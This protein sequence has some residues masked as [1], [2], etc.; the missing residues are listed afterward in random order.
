MNKICSFPIDKLAI[1][2]ICICITVSCQRK[3]L[4][5]ELND[6]IVELPGTSPLEYSDRLIDELH[7]PETARLIGVGEATHGTRE[8]AELRLRLLKYLVIHKGFRCLVKEFSF[9]GSLALNQYILNGT[10]NLDTLLVNFGWIH[11]SNEAREVFIWMREYNTGKSEEDRIFFYGIDTQLDMWNMVNHIT[12]I[13]NHDP[14]VYEACLEHFDALRPYMELDYSEMPYNEYSHVF[15]E[16]HKLQASIRSYYVQSRQNKESA[17]IIQL[18]EALLQ[19]HKFLYH[20][21]R[22][23]NPKSYREL[24]L[25]Q[26][27]CWVMEQMCDGAGVVLWAHNAHIANNPHYNQEGG[28]AL[29]RH[30]SD[31]LHEKYYHIGISFS[32]GSFIAVNL[33]SNGRD[34]PPV[35]NTISSLPPEQSVNG[36]LSHA[37]YNNF[38]LDLNRI[39]DN[40]LLHIF[41][42]TLRPFLDIGDLYAGHPE[43][44]FSKEWD[45][46]LNVRQ[47]FDMLFYFKKTREVTLNKYWTQDSR[48]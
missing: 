9:A 19:S 41:M 27:T 45:A 26:N 44:H 15:N 11:N 48:H 7:I 38:A 17:T 8:F 47:S 30:L 43:P 12:Y 42:D 40:S 24:H 39:S 23:E 5:Q 33:D 6:Y 31:F 18:A 22:E 14:Q 10:G 21:Y 28:G 13:M 4:V 25:A 20:I 1:C 16:L 29:G 32:M 36:L 2:L 3:T 35:I 34:T 46:V 37:K